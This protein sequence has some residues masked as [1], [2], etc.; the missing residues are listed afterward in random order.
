MAA[1]SNSRARAI[2]NKA[3]LPSRILESQIEQPE[4]P[5]EG[6]SHETRVAVPPPDDSTHLTPN[7]S[8]LLGE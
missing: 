5:V 1:Q 7:V 3:I 6:A 8:E 4:R 2:S